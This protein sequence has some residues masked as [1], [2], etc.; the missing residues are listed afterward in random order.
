M[1][2]FGGSRPDRLADVR[3]QERVQ[4]HTVDQIVDSV[5]LPTLHVPQV[6][7]LVEVLLIPECPR[8][9]LRTGSRGEPRSPEPR[10][11]GLRRDLAR[12]EQVRQRTAMEVMR[13]F[14]DPVRCGALTVDERFSVLLLMPDYGWRSTASPGRC[15]NTGQ[16]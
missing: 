4:R 15:T 3:P 10:V 2:E 7:Q 12:L 14:V 5:R 8:L 13:W 9:L 11:V 16:G 1:P 6:E